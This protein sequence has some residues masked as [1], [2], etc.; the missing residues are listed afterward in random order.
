MTTGP[1]ATASVLADIS[2]TDARDLTF[3][4]AAS[5]GI[6]GRSSSR[7]SVVDGP[8]L[9]AA[10]FFGQSGTSSKETFGSNK[11]TLGRLSDLRRKHEKHEASKKIHMLR[12]EQS[13]LLTQT[14]PDTPMGR[15][16][17]RYWIPALL[18]EELPDDDCPPVRV[19]A[20][21]APAGLPDSDGRH[22]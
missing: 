5:E 18:A 9:S 14:G 16:F 21:G 3:I 20:G 19:V 6:G 17:R 10:A 2:P 11:P 12:R 15:M 1:R 7:S 8:T 22:G 13:D 4:S